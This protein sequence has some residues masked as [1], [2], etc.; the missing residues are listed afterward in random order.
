MASYDARKSELLTLTRAI[1]GP[2]GDQLLAICGQWLVRRDALLAR[3]MGLVKR[4]G[5]G[6][7]WKA[8]VAAWAS[9]IET[10]QKDLK[11]IFFE[12]PARL[13]LDK[14]MLQSCSTLMEQEG[15]FLAALDTAPVIERLGKLM[16]QRAAMVLMQKQLDEKWTR[17]L[18][19]TDDFIEPQAAAIRAISREANALAYMFSQDATVWK[20]LAGKIADESVSVIERFDH[21][22]DLDPEDALEVLGRAGVVFTSTES[23]VITILLNELADQLHEMKAKA[24]RQMERV[25][26]SVRSYRGSLVHQG[27]V[28]RLFAEE[29]RLANLY[30]EKH[31]DEAETIEDEIVALNIWISLLATPGQKADGATFMAELEGM[32]AVIKNDN[33]RVH[34]DFTNRYRG[35]FIEDVSAEITDKIVGTTPIRNVLG[36][37]FDAFP[38]EMER[39]FQA[40]FDALKDAVGD[41]IEFLQRLVA[42]KAAPPIEE[43]LLRNLK[44][45]EDGLKTHLDADWNSLTDEVTEI[46]S[47]VEEFDMDGELSREEL[48]DALN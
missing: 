10:L 4:V 26:E 14:S 20:A 1:G 25:S 15:R 30:I 32:V 2:R 38:S 8:L 46:V 27:S 35:L 34:N 22:P 36:D 3:L 21:W 39:L 45:I 18:D 29:R 33:T 16:D 48:E 19:L 17:F 42:S 6:G 7:D 37:G 28:I 5:D 23:K 44:I 24:R 13:K 41:R 47:V 40:E 31:V 11:A 43:L 12:E 9:D